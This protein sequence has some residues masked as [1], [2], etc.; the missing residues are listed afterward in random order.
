MLRCITFCIS[1]VVPL[2]HHATQNEERFSEVQR[3]V[4]LRRPTPLGLTLCSTNAQGMEN[5]EG[6]FDRNRV[7]RAISYA[8]LILSAEGKPIV[9]LLELI[10]LCENV[11]SSI[12]S[13]IRCR[14]SCL[15]VVA[16]PR[17]SFA[18]SSFSSS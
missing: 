17:L 3:H 5:A 2:Y 15:I 11:R 18:Q 4:D 14:E 6:K 9:T 12:E 1:Y 7:Q 16:L 8:G 10:V 13:S